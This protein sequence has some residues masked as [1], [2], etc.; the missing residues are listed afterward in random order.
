MRCTMYPCYCRTW[1]SICFK[2]IALKLPNCWWIVKTLQDNEAKTD[3][4]WT[5]SQ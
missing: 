4:Q 2:T 5:M 3:G 1:C